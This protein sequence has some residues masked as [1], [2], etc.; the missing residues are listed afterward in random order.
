MVAGGLLICSPPADSQRGDL[1][2]G[3][4][5][6]VSSCLFVTLGTFSSGGGLEYLYGGLVLMRI[7]VTTCGVS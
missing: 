7:S 2:L 5:A 4:L 6:T 1:L 3:L